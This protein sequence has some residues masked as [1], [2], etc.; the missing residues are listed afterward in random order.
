MLN[1]ILYNLYLKFQNKDFNKI[2]KKIDNILKEGD[3]DTFLEEQLKKLLFHSYNTVPYYNKIFE[4]KNIVINKKDI[5]L[6]KFHDIPILKKED[7]KNKKLIS[8]DYN[9][10]GHYENFSG[11][12]TG[13]PTKFIQDNEYNKWV[14]ATVHWY[15]SHF[16]GVDSLVDKKVILW[17][18]VD[19]LFKNK[20][21]VSKKLFL[22]FTNTIL[23]NSFK[24]SHEDMNKY[25]K[26]INKFKPKFIRAYSNSIF[27]LSK[28]IEKYN[29]NIHSPDVLVT[30]AETLL[31][32]MRKKIESVWGVK[33]H[34]F[35]GSR[36]TAA[37][38]GEC[39]HGLYQ[40]FN[41]NNYV[42]ILDEQNRK[43][44]PGEKGKIVITNLHNYSMPFIRYEIGDYAFKSKE[45]CMC[46]YPFPSLSKISG[47]I[48][49]HFIRSDG[50]I[51]IGYFFVHLFGVLLNNNIIQKIQI[52]QVNYEE[53]HVYF[54]SNQ[55]INRHFKKDIE[56]KIKDVMGKECKIIWKKV[57]NIKPSRSGKYFYTKSLVNKS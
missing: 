13:I 39:K 35:Y 34:D 22:K 21:S 9:Q 56:S 32:E 6:S 50:E 45:Q 49:E 42:E 23:L 31:P 27:E 7:L 53:I 57:N 36:E 52:I 47:R 16:L 51:V 12:S 44:D 40:I 17:G 26:I 43:V 48:E 10:R 30:S 1:R 29:K 20:R 38:A 8:K 55:D 5:D 18:S 24:M 3:V 4:E 28:H 2:L 11:G 54:V 15:Y 33:V 19:D 37:I 41:F 14:N 46:K 25:I